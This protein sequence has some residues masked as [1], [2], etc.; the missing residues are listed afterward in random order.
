M[1]MAQI[2][3]V[4]AQ[5]HIV[6]GTQHIAIAFMSNEIAEGE[7]KQLCAIMERRINGSTPR[8]FYVIRH[9]QGEVLIDVDAITAVTWQKE[10]R[11]PVNLGAM[12]SGL[13]LMRS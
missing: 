2:Q 12:P 13:P 1:P 9:D 5:L 11:V 10:Q 7:W 8:E 4:N 6:F 3:K